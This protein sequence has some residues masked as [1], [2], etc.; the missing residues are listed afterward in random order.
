MHYSPWG[1]RELDMTERP[2][3]LHSHEAGSGPLPDTKSSGVL[4]LH[5]Q[6][7]GPGEINA[8]GLGSGLWCLLHTP[9]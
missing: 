6:H 7:P 4:T 9:S 3:L 2:A 8:C 5:V 1:H